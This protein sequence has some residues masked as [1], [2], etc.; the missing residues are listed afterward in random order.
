MGHDPGTSKEGPLRFLPFRG[1]RGPL[2]S[3]ETRS[4]GEP[5]TRSRRW[6][7]TVTPKENPDKSFHPQPSVP[8]GGPRTVTGPPEPTRVT[9]TRGTRRQEETVCESDDTVVVWGWFVDDTQCAHGLDQ[10][11]GTR[12]P[13][14]TGTPSPS[15][16]RAHRPKP[17]LPLRHSSPGGPVMFTREGGE[18]GI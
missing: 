13:T 8:G 1:P 16:F 11:V 9:G 2:L 18:G 4:L 7:S 3:K 10:G 5:V 17:F 15:P 6:T 12:P 14:G